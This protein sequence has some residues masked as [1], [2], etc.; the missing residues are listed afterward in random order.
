MHRTPYPSHIHPKYRFLRPVAKGPKDTLKLLQKKE[1]E[2]NSEELKKWYPSYQ[3]KETHANYPFLFRPIISHRKGVL[4]GLGIHSYKEV[5]K[6]WQRWLGSK[7]LNLLA[8]TP[9]SNSIPFE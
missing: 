9:N 2:L 3:S 5:C 4:Q 6:E 1:F 7:L 8:S